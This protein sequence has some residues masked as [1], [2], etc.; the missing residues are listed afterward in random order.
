MDFY[1]YKFYNLHTKII[2]FRWVRWEH[3]LENMFLEKRILSDK[4]KMFFLSLSEKRKREFLG[5]RYALRY[6][7]MKMNIFYNEKRKPFL[8]SEGKYISL[9]HSF[10]KIAIAISSYHI[11]IDIEKLRH[12]IVKIKKKFLREDES[13]FIN[14]NY[15]EDYLHI[16]WGIKESLY[17][18][19]GGIFYSFLD[20]YKVSPF[21]LK[22]DSCISCWIIKKTYSKKY[23]AFYR[24]IEEHYLVYII[25]K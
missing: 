12:K 13:I 24:K 5:I 3:F 10:E 15:E 4:E 1:P 17:K 2:V 19:E 11:G 23:S 25:D 20:H 16:I 21:C 18:L 6:I 8:F 22:K 14:P 7:G 9:S